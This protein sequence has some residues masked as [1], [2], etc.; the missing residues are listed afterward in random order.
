MVSI[1]T[2][3]LS[4]LFPVSRIL[5]S[6]FCVL[7]PS[8]RAVCYA[9]CVMC[10]R[11]QWPR[12]ALVAALFAALAVPAFAQQVELNQ[13]AAALAKQIDQPVV[14]NAPKAK[15]AIFMF[16]HADRSVSQLGIMLADRFAAALSHEAQTF[17]LLDAEKLESMRKQELWTEREVQVEGIACAVA[18]MAGAGIVI[19]GKH[20]KV[21][22]WLNGVQLE[23]RA[24]V[25]SDGKRKTIGKVRSSISL[26]QEWSLLDSQ[27][28]PS[29]QEK[30]KSDAS[31]ESQLAE[32]VFKP[33][34]DRV[35]FPECEYCPDPR[36]SDE[37]RAAKYVAK[38]LLRLTV[39]VNGKATDIQV[40]KPAKLGLTQSAFETVKTWRFKPA[41]DRDGKPVPVRV[42]IEIVF[43]LPR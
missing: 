22:D 37:A 18:R 11:A 27:P 24:I 9:V 12:I 16:A 38:V 31:P 28:A 14:A 25:A 29:A 7:L 41:R 8:A 3:D 20:E 21:R 2:K 40:I 5:I 43:R 42:D 30:T 39:S 34:K 6:S 10:R 13:L 4:Q 35:S 23:V 26:P 33:G 1:G 36:F 19:L 15:V 32:G 17:E